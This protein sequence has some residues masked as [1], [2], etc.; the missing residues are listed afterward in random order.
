MT[1][2]QVGLLGDFGRL[3]VRFEAP[4]RI[5]QLTVKERSYEVDL[6]RTP[7]TGHLPL[8]GLKAQVRQVTDVTLNL[9]KY[10]NKKTDSEGL[11]TFEFRVTDR[12]G[13]TASARL[14]IKV[15][16]PPSDQKERTEEVVE[17]SAFEITRIA[18]HHVTGAEAFGITWTT[19]ES[20][21]VVIKLTK[22]GDGAGKLVTIAPAAYAAVTTREEL[23]KAI[24]NG[25][26]MPALRLETA[27]NTAAGAVFGVINEGAPYLLSVTESDASSSPQGTTVRL[28]G[29]YKH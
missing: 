17:T 20:E 29:E 15:V 14:R 23:S 26:E 28:L 2:T 21:G 3:R 19:V 22:S 16:S 18:T 24:E 4:H 1:E 9:E 13:K 27:N 10:I 6:A 11:Y 25:T 5:E 12:K 7:E 8:F